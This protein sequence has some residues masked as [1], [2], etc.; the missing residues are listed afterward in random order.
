MCS[1]CLLFSVPNICTVMRKSG[2]SPASQPGPVTSFL[3]QKGVWWW[4]IVTFPPP[5]PRS[6]CCWCS[7]TCSLQ[8]PQSCTVHPAPLWGAPSHPCAW[9]SPGWVTRGG[10]LQS[11]GCCA[12]GQGCCHNPHPGDTSLPCAHWP[13][14]R[15]H[16]ALVW[17]PNPP[18]WDICSGELRCRGSAPCVMERLVP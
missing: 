18:S 2:L 11:G 14:A 5:L 16:R 15:L 6:R 3:F 13:S 1:C 7:V 4:F 9:G 12:S 17:L 10:A 8:P